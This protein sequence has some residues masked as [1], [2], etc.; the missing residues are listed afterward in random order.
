[1]FPIRNTPNNSLIN[2]L[3]LHL[4]LSVRFE[5]NNIFFKFSELDGINDYQH[6][7]DHLQ[8]VDQFEWTLLGP[9]FNLRARE[10]P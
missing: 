7:P 1:M 4:A 5:G 10:I 9:R 3:V 6:P 8:L 2:T